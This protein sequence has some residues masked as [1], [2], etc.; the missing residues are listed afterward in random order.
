MDHSITSSNV[1]PP[2]LSKGNLQKV[3]ENVVFIFDSTKLQ[4][5]PNFP[6]EFVW[7]DLEN[8]SH[9]E[10]NEPL[11]DMDG[12]FKGDEEAMAIA[13]ELIRTACMKHGFFQITNHGINPVLIRAAYDEIDP[14]FML[15]MDK[16]LSVRRKPGNGMVG[17]EPRKYPDFTWLELLEFT[18]HH[19]RADEATLKNFTAWFM[20]SKPP[21]V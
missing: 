18:Q 9:E 3:D 7:P 16:K 13:A 14:I 10:L 15:P 4:K 19:Y 11:I 17:E 12:I 8:S 2:I 21:N 1:L 5:Q 6:E 20:S